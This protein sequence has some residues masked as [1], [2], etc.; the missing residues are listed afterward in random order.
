MGGV[1]YGCQ[2]P[3]QVH[4]R[5]RYGHFVGVFACMGPGAGPIRALSFHGV[6]V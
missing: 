6:K 3:V 5:D 4:E 1:D 2:V